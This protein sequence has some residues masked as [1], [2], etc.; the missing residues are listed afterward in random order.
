MT[1]G[2]LALVAPAG[3]VFGLVFAAPMALLFVVSF[4]TV[5]NYRL[6]PAFTLEAWREAF[7][8]YAALGVE[9]LAVGGLIGALCVALGFGFAWIA[10][11]R[12]GRHGDALMLAALITLFGGYL[13]KVYAWK[14]I[15][16][17]D[18][19]MN[20]ALMGLGLTEAPVAALIYSRGAVVVALVHFLLPFAILPIYAALRN[21]PEATIEAARDLGAGPAAVLA[22]VILPQIRAGLFAAFAFCFLL[23]AGDYVTPMLLGGASG[24]MLGQF[25][26]LEFSTNFDWPAGAAMSF[27]LVAACLVAL[28]LIGAAGA[29]L[30]R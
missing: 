24:R 21:V 9:T 28:G 10:R 11:F 29:R 3:A 17:A 4:W 12:A 8:D 19:L 15:L 7:A 16:G 25:V 20:Q 1:R 26:L 5:R 27:G 22:R 13:V 6:T 14:A 30:L 18:G 2:A 23:A